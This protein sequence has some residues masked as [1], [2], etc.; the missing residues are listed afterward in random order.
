MKNKFLVV[1][2]VAGL[3]AVNVGGFIWRKS[4]KEAAARAAAEQAAAQKAAAAAVAAAQEPAP[5]ARPA[6]QEELERAQDARAQRAL[7]VAALESGD[8]ERALAHFKEAQSLLGARA[9]VDE[10]I[11]ATED[12][13]ARA[14][15]AAEAPVV[16]AGTPAP[17]PA[18]APQP[19]VP[20]AVAP[21]V[22]GGQPVR[23]RP[24][25]PAGKATSG[26]SS[27][28]T[29]V[30]LVSTTPRG[31]LVK[32]DGKGMD[33]SP[34]RVSVPVG[35][36]RV[37]LL[38]GDRVLF[39]TT[40]DV[41]EEQV[42]TVLKDLSADLAPKPA[43]PAAAPA[44]PAPPAES[45]QPAALPPAAPA[46]VTGGLEVASP[47][48]YGEIWVNGR[49]QGFPPLKLDNLAPGPVKIEVRVNGVVKRSATANVVAG[50]TTP[51]RV[52]R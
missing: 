18:A 22:Q 32:V 4:R 41:A 34:M 15:A 28:G 44:A 23:P 43:A 36:H 30:L 25:V 37:A 7:G 29:G 40:V 17:V 13:R 39:E 42:V 27:P 5:Q 38:D 16:D 10:L 9:K 11:K 3:L 24:A 2:L 1:A 26:P 33:L 49:P 47:G 8:Y 6:D 20:Q 21:Q 52:V 31:L 19:T 12:L 48:L 14:R 45:P 46:K 35:S 50:E 51:V